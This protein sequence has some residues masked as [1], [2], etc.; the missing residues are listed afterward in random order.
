MSIFAISAFI[1]GILGTIFGLFVFIR[2]RRN[3]VNQTFALLTFSVALWSFSYWQWQL[4]S[5]KETALFWC[6]LLTVGS[7]FIP[8]TYLHWVLSVIKKQKN[9]K[10]LIIGYVLSL[11][12]ASFSFSPLI[13][14]DVAPIL[15]FSWW[16]VAGP[17]YTVYV[18]V[19]YLGL[20]T[21]STY[22][23]FL[24]YRSGSGLF[25]LQLKY[26]IIG[27]IIG[28][29][30]GLTNF[31]LWYGVKI[32]P[33]GNIL[34]AAYPIAFTYSI[35]RFR[36][37]DIRIAMR[38]L[39]VRLISVLLL[40]LILIMILYFYKQFIGIITVN[41]FYIFTISLAL[42]TLIFYPPLLTFIRNATDSILFQKEYS[43]EELL[44]TLGKTMS[45]SIDLEILIENIKDV[46][47]QV[48]RMKFVAFVFTPE[49]GEERDHYEMRTY[50]PFPNQ[51]SFQKGN[52]LLDQFTHSSEILIRDE[53]KRKA[54]EA[55]SPIKETM[56][57][58]VEE[59]DKMQA[60]VMVPLPAT[61]GLEG[62]IILGEKSNGDAYTISDIQ[63]LETLMYQAGTAIENA[64]LYNK[65]S[66]FSQ[67]LQKEVKRATE[68]LVE[69]N[70]FLN[71]LGRLDQI[72]MNTL[73]LA[74]MCQKIADT[75]SWEMGYTGGI[76]C[77]IDEKKGVLA[78]Q[79]LSET[80]TFKKILPLLPKDIT[81]LNVSLHD[82]QHPLIQALL[83]GEIRVIPKLSKLF[84]PPLEIATAEK[85][86]HLTRIKANVVCPLSAKGKKLGVIII[87]LTQGFIELGDK[88]RELIQAF[89]DQ[90]GIAIENASLYSA[91]ESINRELIKANAHLRE[92][93]KMKDEFV[94]I[95]SHELRTPMTAIKGY[96]WMITNGK[97][98]ASFNSQQ[99]DYIERVK[100]STERLINLVNDMLDVSRIEGG[101]MEMNIRAGFVD[102]VIMA[103]IAD[104]MP[105][106]L[107]KKI[108]LTFDK[109]KRTLPHVRIDE[110]RIREVLINLIGNALKFTEPNGKIAITTKVNGRMIEVSVRDT[111]RG[112]AKKDIPKLFQK[113]GRLEHSFALISETAG[114]GLGL[115][116]TKSIVEL[117]GGKIW[118]KSSPGKGSTFSFSL[119]VAD[120]V[121]VAAEPLS[122]KKDLG[123]SPLLSMH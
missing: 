122:N 25:R 65:V 35:I 100:A 74:P 2:S 7:T 114:T 14:K 38:A 94:S 10:I 109:P 49:K 119:R 99:E 75:I 46:L 42:S 39:V 67:K 92:L 33:F 29:I 55:K 83:G 40:I 27:S 63:T 121:E 97:H 26:V 24:S 76:I 72:I 108:E 30:G 112:I 22:H 120:E 103:A 62:A 95:A 44:R 102:H 101:R 59:M 6:H 88:E 37:L 34:V 79:S 32:V 81:N 41:S 115:Y 98:K 53:L 47:I 23:L 78:A 104:I 51:Y 43:H 3:I 12:L 54:E 17:L 36:F 21:Y 107:E 16:P 117:H 111:G 91:L 61:K 56:E 11:V 20:A 58:I 5:T 85:I 52:F 18:L 57:K 70:K 80:P 90:S 66:T 113:F 110:E 73:G 8:I 45:E 31:P 13:V 106:A 28:F 69:K 105:K 64:R 15:D 93:D 19:L 87:G 4:S 123:I 9:N 68:D 77:L 86:Q 60:Q 71:T 118:V 116:I 50:G 48:M 89:V 1:N 82:E 96:L 84:C